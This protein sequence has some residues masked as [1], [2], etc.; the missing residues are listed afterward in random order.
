MKLAPGLPGQ[1]SYILFRPHLTVGSE[2]P[3]GRTE[4]ANPP[5]ELSGGTVALCLEKAS[6]SL[7]TDSMRDTL[8][9][10]LMQWLSLSLSAAQVPNSCF[11]CLKTLPAV[12]L[13]TEWGGLFSLQKHDLPFNTGPANLWCWSR[14]SRPQKETPRSPD[15]KLPVVRQERVS[16][17]QGRD[18]NN[19]SS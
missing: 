15:G 18:N 2:A 16:E 12:L 6:R 10:W 5:L 13:E 4:T 9:P 19:L 8:T 1:C 14:A 7:E 11:P 3:L 17:G